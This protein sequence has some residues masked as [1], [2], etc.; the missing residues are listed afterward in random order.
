MAEPAAV[1]KIVIYLIA[2]PLIFAIPLILLGK[3]ANSWMESENERK[4]KL[5]LYILLII[6]TV[7]TFSIAIILENNISQLGALSFVLLATITHFSLKELRNQGGFKTKTW[8]E[9]RHEAFNLGFRG[10]W[11]SKGHWG[12]ILLIS[13]TMCGILIQLNN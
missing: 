1:I 11:R 10:A 13:A 2:I 9:Q 7:V 3:F 5:S 6:I 4:D 12:L 8:F